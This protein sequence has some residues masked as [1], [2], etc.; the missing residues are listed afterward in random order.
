M[1]YTDLY[2]HKGLL[3]KIF[4]LVGVVYL[5][6]FSDV[7]DPEIS[8]FYMILNFFDSFYNCFSLSCEGFDLSLQNKKFAFL[9][10]FCPE[11]FCTMTY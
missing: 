8:K 2:F 3:F 10:T 6:L 11:A 9:S 5:Q 4:F 7:V 1:I